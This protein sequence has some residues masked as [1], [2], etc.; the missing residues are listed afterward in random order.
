MSSYCRTAAATG[1]V[2]QRLCYAHLFGQTLNRF[3][4]IGWCLRRPLRVLLLTLALNFIAFLW[5]LVKYSNVEH[6]RLGGD[7]LVP[8]ILAEQSH[9][10]NYSIRSA[11]HRTFDAKSEL[12]SGLQQRHLTVLV[13]NTKNDRWNQIVDLANDEGSGDDKLSSHKRC[14]YTTNRN[15]FNDSAGVLFYGDLMHLSRFPV[16]RRPTRQKWIYLSVE[17]P[18]NTINTGIFISQK[19][20]SHRLCT[21]FKEL[22]TADTF[23]VG[24]R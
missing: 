21:F 9:G 11:D 3:C 2:G 12:H 8:S 24:S 19:E 13:W 14:V 4:P 10:K 7:S 18:V 23:A 15:L 20:S 6:P 1:N 17:T 16:E 22:C 5:S